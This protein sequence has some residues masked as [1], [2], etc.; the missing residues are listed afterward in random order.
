MPNYQGPGQT[1]PVS[2]GSRVPSLLFPFLY[3]AETKT[4]RRLLCCLEQYIRKGLPAGHLEQFSNP[5]G[6]AIRE[7]RDGLSLQ[8][9]PVGWASLH[10]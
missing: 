5:F 6:F 9:G 8:H 4:T 7:A 2:V 3:S 10:L 1:T